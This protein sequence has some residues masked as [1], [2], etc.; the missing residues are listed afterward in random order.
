MKQWQSKKQTVLLDIDLNIVS[1]IPWEILTF[2][3]LFSIKENN[4][5]IA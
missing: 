2:D 5:N 3:F 1:G 4:L